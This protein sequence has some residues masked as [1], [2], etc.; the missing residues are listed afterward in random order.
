MAEDMRFEGMATVEAL[1]HRGLVTIR[2]DLADPALGAAVEGMGLAVP[3]PLRATMADGR[4]LAWMSPDELL[5]IGPLGEAPERAA[6]LA[7]ALGE[8]H[9]LVADV[10]GGRVGFAVSGAGM[11]DV[12]AKLVPIDL[13]PHA[14]GPGACRRTKL[15][16]VAAALLCAEDARIELLCRR[17]EGAYV[18]AL[19]RGAAAR[20]D[21]AFF[22]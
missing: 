10:S 11:R 8:T 12:L 3:D 7:E 20:G 15:G 18:Q 22:S 16:Q 5:L 13:R 21:V 2:C 14:F 4:A 6:R 17:S 19:L 9:A 1:G